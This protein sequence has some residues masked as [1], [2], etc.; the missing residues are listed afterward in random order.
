M[1]K[2]DRARPTKF[3]LEAEVPKHTS[4]S[5]RVRSTRRFWLQG[6]ALPSGVAGEQDTQFGT[7]YLL[8]NIQALTVVYRYCAHFYL[9]LTELFAAVCC[10]VWA[11][12]HLCVCGRNQK[13]LHR[14]ILDICTD[15]YAPESPTAT[16]NQCATG[17]SASVT[18][19]Y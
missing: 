9:D 11:V 17:D 1:T 3:R 7:L 6:R 13:F 4:W 14:A 15:P 19:K 8:A 5:L 16:I 10:L 18:G 2:N 12:L